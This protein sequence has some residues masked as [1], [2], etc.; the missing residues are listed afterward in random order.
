VNVMPHPVA[1][2]QQPKRTYL[3]AIITLRQ[4]PFAF[5]LDARDFVYHAPPLSLVCTEKIGR[6]GTRLGTLLVVVLCIPG[7]YAGKR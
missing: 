6:L 1:Y 4:P 2:A 3:R 7:L 5:K